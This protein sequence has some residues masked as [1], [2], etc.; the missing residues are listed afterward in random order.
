[1]K[2]I[3]GAFI[4]PEVWQRW[5]RDEA[6]SKFET[7]RGFGINTIFTESET[8]RDDLID[9]A[10]EMGIRWFGGIACFS[11]HSHDQ[12]LLK[13][14]PELWPVLETG[15]RR[16]Q[17]E[18]YVGVT[19]T[20]ED[21]NG[22][23]LALAERLVRE[24]RLD[25]FVLDFVRWPIHWELELR[26]GAPRPLQSS[27][28]PHTLARFQSE[29]GVELPDSLSD[30]PAKAVWILKHHMT[31]WTDFKCAVITAFV[32]AVTARLRALRGPDITLGLYALP[33]SSEMLEALAG[34][35]VSDLAAHVD[36]VLPMAYHAI[37]HRSPAWVGE[38]AREFGAAAPS[39]TLPVVQVDS[40]EGAEAGADWGPPVSVDE[41]E[42]VAGRAL[43]APGTLGLVAFTGTSLFR[44]ARGERLGAMLSVS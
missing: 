3:V 30:T 2:Q 35:R 15:E 7:L 37:L 23:R 26:P 25:G 12:Q 19:P 11:D 1:M 39:K 9:L 34:Q 6:C 42:M 36:V 40:A 32:E 10:H 20:I 21:Y 22:S 18:W 31:E 43:E 33:T 41:W 16:P 38:I 27:F 44:G 24:H 8:Y 28:D 5:S 14:R 4:F 17:M 13:D 29:M